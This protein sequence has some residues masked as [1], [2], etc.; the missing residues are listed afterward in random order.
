MKVGRALIRNAKELFEFAKKDLTKDITRPRGCDDKHFRRTILY[1]PRE[2]VDHVRAER[3]TNTVP[4][5]R[6]IHC[7]TTVREGVVSTRDLTCFCSTVHASV[8]IIII[9][10]SAYNA[11]LIPINWHLNAQK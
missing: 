5:T 10:C 9:I 3:I 8:E 6:T 11:Q 4:G 2:E 7:M 1:V